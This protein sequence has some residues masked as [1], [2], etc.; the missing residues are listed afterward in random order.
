MKE[1]V[2]TGKSS[3]GMHARPAGMFVKLAKQCESV[4][5]VCK[6]D[7]R[8]N[9]SRI[10]AVMGMGIQQGDTITL[11]VEGPDEETVFPQLRQ[12]CEENL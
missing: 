11:T 12:I 7:K 2:Y 8:V 1:Y 4:I 10:L 5:E 6:G 9:V 3:L